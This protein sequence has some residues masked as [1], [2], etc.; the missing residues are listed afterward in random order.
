VDHRLLAVQDAARRQQ[1]GAHAQ[2]GDFAA[3]AV[4]A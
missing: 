3:I 2:A 4:M 1:R